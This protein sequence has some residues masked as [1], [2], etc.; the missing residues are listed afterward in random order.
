MAENANE[1]AAVAEAPAPSAPE[2]PPKTGRQVFEKAKAE[3]DTMRKAERSSPAESE[4]PEPATAAPASDAAP[5]P[6]DK[7]E[8]SRREQGARLREQIRR[9]VE[10]EFQATQQAQRQREVAEQQQKEFDELV[11]RADSGDWEA[12][13][14]VLQLLKSQ[15]GMTTAINQGRMAVLAELGQDITKA[16]YSLEGLDD[17][18]QQALLKAPSVAEFGKSAFEHGRKVEKAIHEGTIATLKAENESLKGRLAGNGPSPTPTNGSVTS[19]GKPTK[20]NSVQEAFAAAA[21]EL[22]YRPQ[23]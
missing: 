4:A 8:G 17:D 14:R 22:N 19:P 11:A 18:A 3:L 12:K 5:P 7:Q 1:Q 20:F 2:S 6:T 13:D 9:E 15:K 10:A 16:V 21:A 23:G